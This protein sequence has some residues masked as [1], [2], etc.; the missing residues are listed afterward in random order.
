MKASLLA[1]LFTLSAVLLSST[2]VAAAEGD[3]GAWP[4][5]PVKIVVGFPAGGSSDVTA[6]I[7]ADYLANEWDNAVIVENRPGAGGTIAAAH[8]AAA[9]PDGHTLFLIPPGTHAVS[10][11]MYD[12]L[13]YHPIDGFTSISRVAKGPYFIL[14][15]GS[16]SMQ[17]IDDLVSQ[18]KA[19][20]GSISFASTGEGSG[21]HFVGESIAQALDT[22]FL[23][24]PYKGAAPATLALMSDEVDFAI[25]DISAMPN[26]TGGTLRALAVTTP[27]RY[28][29]LPEVPT[30]AESGVPVE[31]TVSVGLS[32][33][34]NLPA[35]LVVKLNAAVADALD[36]DTVKE[37]LH[38]LGFEPAPTTPEA[39]TQI[40]ADDIERFQAFVA[41]AGLKR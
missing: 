25:S 18:A 19:D 23:H 2:A 5:R 4:E 16:S 8:V 21:A 31:Y 38:S 30:L 22:E 11:A 41:Q 9:P 40:I 24:V 35:D 20:P 13:P 32:S 1:K 14:V 29:Q 39:L 28:S 15:N 36:D 17:T 10:S 3:A 6:R 27:Q 37:R 34:A 26:I 7:L 12:S 33:S